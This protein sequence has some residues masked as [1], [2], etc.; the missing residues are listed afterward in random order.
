VTDTEVTLSGATQDDVSL[1]IGGAFVEMSPNEMLV[2]YRLIK[3]A[4]DF[5]EY[6]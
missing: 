3:Q 5:G 2:A 6:I 4:L 1:T